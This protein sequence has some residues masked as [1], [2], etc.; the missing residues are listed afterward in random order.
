MNGAAMC[1]AMWGQLIVIL[2]WWF[3]SNTNLLL[4]RIE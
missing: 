1:K 2:V 4:S 3:Y